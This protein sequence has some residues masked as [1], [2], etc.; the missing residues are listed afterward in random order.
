[1]CS[2][3]YIV[4]SDEAALEKEVLRLAKEKQHFRVRLMHSDE[5]IRKL[6]GENKALK[7]DIESLKAELTDERDRFDRLTDFELD[8]SKELTR[9]RQTA[10]ERK[11]LFNIAMNLLDSS[12]Y[13]VS[14]LLQDVAEIKVAME[15]Q[16]GRN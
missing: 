13:N 15:A 8:E 14:K 1:M 7:A 10:A 9:W 4:Y 2:S 5:I 6:T 3:D 11:L 16:N 12:G